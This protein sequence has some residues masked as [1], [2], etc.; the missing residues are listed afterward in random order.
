M[1]RRKFLAFTAAA[2]TAAKP[3]AARG[4]DT[5]S[6]PWGWPQPYK[7]ISDA[8][9][10][11]LKDNGWW[12]L[13]VGNQPAFT[14]L[15]AAQGKGF[16]TQRGLEVV[17]NAFLSGPAIN[18]A[19][20]SG[21]VQAGLEGNFP[22]T[23]LLSRGF[24]VRCVAVVNPNIKHATLVDPGSPLQ[25]IADIKKLPEKASFGIVVGSSAE[26]YFTEALRSHGLDASKDV[27]LKNMKPTDMLI[28]PAG[29][30]GFVQWNPY[31]WDHLLLRKNARQIDSIF[32][33]NFY[34][35]NFWVRNEL[36]E[37]VP[38]VVQALVDGY[39]EG[40]LFTKADLAAANT[41][42][43]ADPMYRGYPPEVINLIN[44]K[45]NNLYKPSWF[46]PDQQFWS[47]ENARVAA[48]LHQTGR[49]QK[50]ISAQDYNENFAPQF[51]K[52]TLSKLGWAI[53]QRPCF[54][55]AG[56]T[57]T[58]G[59]PPYPKYDNEDTLSGEQQFPE[60]GDLQRDWMFKGNMYR[61]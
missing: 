12:P 25:S 61:A 20:A 31:V 41:T 47:T 49:L 59:K 36:I 23:T 2:M 55:P 48:W 39:A 7:R 46:Y 13:S 27:I 52:E 18:E 5:S 24:P 11:W 10:K 38:D 22:Y 8:S 19:A 15:P 4:E 34:M 33:Y 26:F 40:I 16:F 32:D 6:T 42:F 37:N 21:R 54:L 9:I 45:L 3:F 43:Q 60:K 28:M 29:L 51:A 44:E 53:P 30:T 57:G 14:G 50:L 56:W 58:V 1:D 35:G 17:V